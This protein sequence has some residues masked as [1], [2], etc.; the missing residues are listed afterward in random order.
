PTSK[1]LLCTCAATFLG[2]TSGSTAKAHISATKSWTIR[3]GY[4]WQGNECLRRVLSGVEHL[5][6]ASSFHDK[7]EPVFKKHLLL[8]H[9]ELDKDPTNGF[10]ACRAAVADVMFYSQLCAGKALAESPEVAK[11]DCNH[12]PTLACLGKPDEVGTKL[13]FLPTTKTSQQ[14]GDKAAVSPQ[15]GHSSP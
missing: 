14:Q 4:I 8:L 15:P 6:P 13:L 1:E 7:H 12:H 2:C 9:D 10:L 3:K 5:T 11:F